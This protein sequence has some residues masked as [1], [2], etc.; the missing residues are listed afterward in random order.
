[1]FAASPMAAA[2]KMNSTSSPRIMSPLLVSVMGLTLRA[3]SDIV[4]HMREVCRIMI[5]MNGSSRTP[6][7]IFS[8]FRDY[9]E[10]IVDCGESSILVNAMHE[11]T[12]TVDALGIA[13]RAIGRELGRF[14]LY[15]RYA[16]H[17]DEVRWA[18]GRVTGQSTHPVW[19]YLERGVDTLIPLLRG[20]WQGHVGEDDLHNAWRVGPQPGQQGYKLFLA[21]MPP[22]RSLSGR[23]LARFLLDARAQGLIAPQLYYD[24]IKSI[25]GPLNMGCDGFVYNASYPSKHQDLMTPQGRRISIKEN[26]DEVRHAA[27]G[28]K[29]VGYTPAQVL[30]ADTAEL[31]R[32]N[33]LCARAAARHWHEDVMTSGPKAQ[34]DE[35]N[36][37]TV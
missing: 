15:R 21:S 20:D 32:I 35:V 37:E 23:M 5:V 22:S 3:H 16:T 33:I 14:T 8:S 29:L 26:P 34:A 7:V 6:E 30:A 24:G 9:P 1:M 36:L 27:R 10:Q 18:D 2:T 25:S 13:E 12:H 4:N 28:L 19:N 17:V 11:T 31:T